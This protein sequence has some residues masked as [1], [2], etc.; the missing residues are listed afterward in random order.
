MWRKVKLGDFIKV[1][2]GYAFNSKL[3]DTDGD[4]GLI[5]IRD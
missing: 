3:F 4:I 5:R 1:Q 2:N